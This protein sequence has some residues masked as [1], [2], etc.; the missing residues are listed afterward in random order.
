[1]A[2]SLTTNLSLTKPEPG[3]SADSW[4]TK[5]NENFDDLDALFKSDGT[6][7]SVGLNVGSG[8]TL[9]ITGSATAPTA[10]VGTN[11][12]QIATTALVFAAMNALYPV[13]TI[14]SNIS[15]STNP[16][17]LF[18]FGTWVAIA[19]KVVVGLDSGDA[20]FNTAGSTGGNKDSTLVSHNHT[21]SGNTGGQSATHSHGQY[22]L[23]DNGG[24]INGRRDYVADR[25]NNS[26]FTQGVNTMDA[27]N[28]HT[29]GYSGT[30]SSSGSSATNANLQPYVVAYVW[31]R[32]A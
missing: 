9:T 5:L 19:G 31:K 3:A 2:D 14:Y 25:T 32:T 1:M 12:S 22:V 24:P 26:A 8:K 17:T 21:F 20:T 4:G 10:S 11:T 29:H 7:T 15:V 6:G 30:T 18:G 13:G 16:E 23:Y 28:D 27:S